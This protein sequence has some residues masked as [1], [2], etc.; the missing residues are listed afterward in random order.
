MELD[1]IYPGKTVM[2]FDWTLWQKN[3][4]DSKTD[5]FF[6]KALVLKVYPDHQSDAELTE[7]KVYDHPY[8]PRLLAIVRFEHDGR[9]SGGHFVTAMKECLYERA[10]KN[11]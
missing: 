5:S 1:N 3:G 7:K 4:G 2:V 9:E 10:R 6:R 8:H 11:T